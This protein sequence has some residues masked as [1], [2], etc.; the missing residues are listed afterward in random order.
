[1]NELSCDLCQVRQARNPYYIESI[2][3]NIYSIEEL[4]FYLYENIYLVD[5]T[6]MNE[7]L[8]DWIRDELGLKRLYRQLYEQLEKKSGI[9]DFILP[10]F[11]EIGYLSHEEF[12]SLQEQISR[13]EVQQ[14][15]MRQK[16]KGDYLVHCRMY[17]NALAEYQQILRRKGPGNLGAQFY[18]AIWNNMGA[19]Y[20]GLFQFEQAADCLYRSY[21]QV[22]TRETLKK[23]LSALPLFLDEEAYKKKLEELDVDPAFAAK[24]QEQNARLCRLAGENGPGRELEGLEPEELLEVWKEQYGKAT[25]N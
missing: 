4:C 15:D 6:I 16:L 12:R 21:C 8:C 2:S 22:R 7:R 20:A 10:I 1:M 5:H 14:V 17:G 25:R 18:A 9:A 13:L 11:R 23:Y 3:A 24:V 19:A